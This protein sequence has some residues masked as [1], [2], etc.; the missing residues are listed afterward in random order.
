MKKL[1]RI[2]FTFAG[3]VVTASCIQ[4]DMTPSPN[5]TTQPL[6]TAP[7]PANTNAAPAD[8]GPLVDDGT[9]ADAKSLL[10]TF[11]PKSETVAWDGGTW[12]VE[13]NRIFRSQFVKYLNDPEETDKASTQYEAILAQ[14]QQLLTPGQATDANVDQAWKL[15]FEA[16]K[17]RADSQLCNDIADAVY[18]LWQTKSEQ[19]HL[20]TANESIRSEENTLA[21]NMEQSVSQD[22][23]FASPTGKDNASAQASMED[24]QLKREIR[25]KPDQERLA[26]L[27]AQSK[28][29]SVKLEA[30]ELQAKIQ[31][32][33]M[34]VQMF[35]QRRF[36]HVIISCQF[37]QAIFGDGD[38]KLLLGAQIKAMLTS[39]SG[40]DPTVS[41]VSA[42]THEAIQNVNDGVDAYNFMMSKGELDGATERLQ[43]AYAMGQ[44]L[45]A[46][47]T[48]P[49]SQKELGYEYTQKS[50]QLL[51]ALDVKDYDGAQKLVDQLQKMATDF[52]PTKPLA[53][54]QTA[55]TISRM[56]LAKAK[57]AASQNDEKTLETELTAAADIWP[58]N[59]DLEKLSLGIFNQA[60]L[61]QHTLSDLDSLMAQKNYRQIYEDK[62]KYI[63]ATATEPDKAKQL[64]DILEK[65]EEIE[66]SLVQADRYAK[67]GDYRGAWECLEINR[68]TLPEDTKLSEARLNYAT[69][70]ADFVET[71]NTAAQ[72][73]KDGNLG[74]SLSL[75][76][77]AYNDYPPSKLAQEGIQQVVSELVPDIK[78]DAGN[79]TTQDQ[80]NKI[81]GDPAK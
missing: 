77:Q 67:I 66:L 8:G 49:R 11:D 27:E 17:F 45:P 39:S 63:A 37:Y 2:V 34:I 7:Q 1:I 56:H 64:G 20:A 46:I 25:L 59:P 38:Q 16:A 73:E 79:G 71:L 32:Q 75:Y 35:F 61:Q 6:P 54:I 9:K 80:D 23:L 50:N 51:D 12:K 19:S 30:S 5:S 69:Q 53:A 47:K 24:A 22:D 58:R 36:E 31:F 48:L 43:E 81:A 18:A 52:D 21:W 60:D 33:T 76:L 41:V 78:S 40:I 15:L 44:N 55:Q 70:A 26:E 65:M 72:Q 29:N 14:I 4:A 68:R 10:P 74:S 3:W 13:N 42:L 57:A 28:E 62:A